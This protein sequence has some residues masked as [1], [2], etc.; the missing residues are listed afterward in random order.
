[1]SAARDPAAIAMPGQ[2]SGRLSLAWSRLRWSERI[3]IV[4]LIGFTLVAVFAPLVAP[5]DPQI[6]VGPSFSAPSWAHP[7][8]TDEIGRDLLSRVIYGIRLT[9]FPALVIIIAGAVLGAFF[10][11]L[12]GAFGGPTDRFLQRLTDLFLILPSTL[13]A[14]AVVAALGPG[15]F[16][17]VVAITIFWWPW[18]SRIVRSEVRSIAAKPHIEA[19]RLAGVSRRRLLWRYLLPGAMPA[20]IV[21]ATL[22]VANVILILALFSFLGLGA[23]SPAP[24]LGAMSARTLDSLTSA[25]WL[26]ILPA[27]VIFLL[28]MAAN[29]AGD[30]LR[31]AMR[32]T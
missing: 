6:Q 24:E 22:D 5:H 21:T 15:T 32:S 10:G 18:Y 19:A 28:A 20:I 12:S 26:P 7:F 3:A 25:W 14:L 9:W 1:M 13:I 31:N 8:G 2:R 11:L 30:G 17:T 4:A 27:V 23:P 16:N 29:F